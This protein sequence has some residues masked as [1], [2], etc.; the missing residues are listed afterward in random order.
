M[1]RYGGN[2]CKRV[3]TVPS[4]RTFDSELS[5]SD[6]DDDDYDDDDDDDDDDDVLTL[7]LA[8]FPEI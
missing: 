3:R 5:A 7:L 2:P 6:D 1:G 8:H 4:K